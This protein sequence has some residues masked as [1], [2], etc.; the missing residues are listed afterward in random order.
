[1]PKETKVKICGIMDIDT[2]VFC[3]Q[4]G[5]DFIGLNFSPKS[6]RK[7]SLSTALEILNSIQEYF[8]HSEKKNMKIV[9]LFFENTSEEIYS[10]CNQIQCDYV[11]LIAEDKFIKTETLK[12][13]TPIIYSIGVQN[14]ISDSDLT[15][16]RTELLIL[17]TY[18]KGEGGG[19]GKT[20]DWSH[21]KDVRRNYFLAGGLTPENVAEAVKLLKPFGVDVA[22]GVERT[23]GIKDKE[24]IS[25][26]IKNA[27]RF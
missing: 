15:Q 3:A 18:T 6:P 13:D 11:Q 17:D 19:A 16:F 10:T 12:L 4:E 23:R 26:F 2:A 1:M 22:S 14:S 24:K 21:I 7:I 20:F 5:A 9:N 27:K 25:T 8:K